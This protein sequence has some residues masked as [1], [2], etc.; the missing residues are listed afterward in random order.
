MFFLSSLVLLIPTAIFYLQQEEQIHRAI[1]LILLVILITSFVTAWFHA[2]ICQLKCCDFVRRSAKTGFSLSK[3]RELRPPS[4][5][6]TERVEAI[7]TAPQQSVIAAKPTGH[8]QPLE[9]T[10]TKLLLLRVKN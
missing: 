1:S 5:S 7:S 2:L 8:L 10:P 9:H 4:I 6:S 3:I